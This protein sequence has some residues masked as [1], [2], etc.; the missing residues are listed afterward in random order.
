MNT[1]RCMDVMAADL[2]GNRVER[3]TSNG[4]WVLCPYPQWNWTAF[5][6]RIIP[7]PEVIYVNKTSTGIK[8][9]HMSKA[10][11]LAKANEPYGTMYEYIGKV[12][13]E[14]DNV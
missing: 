9:L 10:S 13:K 4:D 8:S 1:K 7:E 2:S 3:R 5:D 6:Y 11:A 14:S 12:F